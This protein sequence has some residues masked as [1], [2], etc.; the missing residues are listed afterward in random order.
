M[1]RALWYVQLGNFEICHSMSY[2]ID[3]YTVDNYKHA[4]KATK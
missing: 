2:E 4:R 3:N 1:K